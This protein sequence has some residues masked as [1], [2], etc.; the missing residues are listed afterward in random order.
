[1]IR[2]LCVALLLGASGVS[3]AVVERTFTL[4]DSERLALLNDARLLSA[5]QDKVIAGERVREAKY[6]FL[7]EFGLQA[8]A[9]KFESRYPFALSGESRNI[10]LF[11]DTPQLYGRNTGEIYSG[12]G[13]MHMPLWEGGRTLNTLRL[14]QAAQKQAVSNHEAVRMDL[15]LSVREVFYRL[16]LAQ[17]RLAASEQYLT[18]VEEFTAKSRQDPWER[19]ESEARVGEAR[20]RASEARHLLGLSRL[21]FLKSLNLELDTPFRV[22]GEL[23]A[24]PVD[25]DVEKAVLW[26]MELRPE[27]QTETYRAQMDAISVNLAQ[28]RRLPT[29]FIGGDYEVTGLDFPLRQN[30]WDATIGIKIPFSYDFW[31]QLRQKRAE[32]RQGQLKRA[33]LQDRVRLEVRQAYETLL[34][35]QKEWPLREAQYRRVESLYSAASGQ[36]GPPL[37]KIRAMGGVLDLRV[38]FLSAVTEHI[39]AK[40]KVERAVGRP[41]EP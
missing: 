30:N 7:P 4:E 16:I 22:V 38:A 11:P 3:A 14:A 28:A 13:Y 10:L 35:W 25:L 26:S 9:T 17:E 19:I 37:S 24:K 32:Q 41:L 15:K 40:A 39:L 6:L 23:T 31:T 34:Y 29:V 33:E 2:A 5:E 20:A 8:S 18:A 36:A 21:A 1:M 12:R 27:L